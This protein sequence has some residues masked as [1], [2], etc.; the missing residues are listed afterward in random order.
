VQR[1]TAV[2]AVVAGVGLIVFTLATSLHSR[3]AAAEEI[4][5][6]YRGQMST[7]GLAS[8]RAD[9]DLIAR[10]RAEFVGEVVPAL[11]RQLDLS[12]TEFDALVKERFPAIP[13]AVATFPTIDSFVGPFIGKLE[14][15]R[16]T[17]ESA[18]SLPG[19]GLPIDSTPWLIAGLG[20][21]LALAGAF[22]LARGTRRSTPAILVLGLLAVIVPLVASVPGK[23]SDAR[24]M[25]DIG[26]L[27]LNKEAATFAADTTDKVYAL[28]AQV[29][30]E[31]IPG[32]ARRL[33]TTPE[34]FTQTLATNF[35]ATANL[36]QVWPE[37]LSEKAHGIAGRMATY[38]PDLA[39][40]DKIPLKALAWVVI[41]PGA[42]LALLA[43][44]ALSRVQ[45]RR[46]AR[47]PL[48]RL[49]RSH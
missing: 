24:E 3:T 1:I 48:P 23:A 33:D 30:T 32:V 7:A 15:N 31:M 44:I 29:T 2:L 10:G 12:R 28:V 47:T 17:F 5:D 19:A 34:E 45:L 16:E 25:T 14:A 42:I 40:T 9:Y 36:L 49:S 11:A 26:A 38:T 39:K 21:A 6:A 37:R 18:D 27:V 13:A 35:P 43:I 4:T 22:G 46:Q 41:V 8:T 20:F